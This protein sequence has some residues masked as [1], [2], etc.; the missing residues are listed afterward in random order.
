MTERDEL[1]AE[2]DLLKKDRED[3]AIVM[4]ELMAERDELKANLEASRAA[5]ASIS[6]AL[7]LS[8]AKTNKLWAEVERLRAD[9]DFAVGQLAMMDERARLALNPE[10]IR[11]EPD[12]PALTQAVEDA[13][14]LVGRT[15]AGLD[16][17]PTEET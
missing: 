12:S 11:P 9:L 17:T 15:R 6:L 1:K 4:S 7:D 5:K 13:R 3:R 16:E 14:G 8:V 2:V 10:E